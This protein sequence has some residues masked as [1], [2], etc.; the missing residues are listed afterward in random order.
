MASCQWIKHVR[1]LRS[2]ET[3]RHQI[4]SFTP[5]R[6]Q[7]SCSG[8]LGSSYDICICL[9]TKMNIRSHEI[10]VYE[11][12]SSII[13]KYF[14]LWH[15]A[16]EAQRCKQVELCMCDLC[17]RTDTSPSNSNLPTLAK[18]Q[19]RGALDTVFFPQS[20]RIYICKRQTLCPCFC[21]NASAKASDWAS[22]HL[23][24]QFQ[25][26][27]HFHRRVQAMALKRTDPGM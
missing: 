1:I 6:Q 20:V 16:F 27:G 11:H 24:V 17:F 13:A 3:R 23:I 4:V 9:A 5:L 12:V 10:V 26:D 22:G 7:W 2:T 19:R 8:R 21:S 25:H 18:V 14:R 15:G